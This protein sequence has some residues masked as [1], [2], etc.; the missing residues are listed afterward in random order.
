MKTKNKTIIEP[1]LYLIPA[2]AI[3]GLFI[4]YPVIRSFSYSFLEWDGLAESTFIGLQNFKELIIDDVF[5]HSLKNTGIWVALSS[6]TLPLGGL[7]LA[8]LIEYGTRS[9]FLAGLTRTVL[10]MPMMMSLVSI[11][12]LWSLIYNP[13]L[14][15]L[16]TM[17]QTIGL[18]DPIN[19]LDLLGNPRTA[20]Y[21]TFIP[22]F[23]QWTGFSMVVFSAAIQ[24]IPGELYQAAAIDG[25]SRIKQIRFITIPLLYPTLV[26][27]MT[28]NV[29]G[30]FK[31]FDLI[32]VMTLGG[33]EQAT[34]VTAIYIFNE[35]FIVHHFGYASTIAVMLFLIT[36]VCSM[37]L[38]RYRRSIEQA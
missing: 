3:L 27:I 20:L 1:Y 34:L 28:I 22:A 31:A 10:F 30:A 7:F 37:L 4:I 38:L 5:W 36:I 33:P 29:I 2:G 11:G 26:I 15:L 12:L 23:W 18:G 17:L 14:G 16:T 6:I 35:A 25:A 32:Y 13:M 8:L 24:G 9:R 21:F 19:P